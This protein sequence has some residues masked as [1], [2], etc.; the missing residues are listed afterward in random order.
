MAEH[1]NFVPAPDDWN[2]AHVSGGGGGAGGSSGW[3]TASLGTYR[4]GGASSVTVET[5]GGCFGPGQQY[6]PGNTFRFLGPEQLF[7]ALIVG[8]ILM[9]KRAD[10]R[11]IR[12]PAEQIRDTLMEQAGAGYRVCALGGGK[13]VFGLNGEHLIGLEPSETVWVEESVADQTVLVKI[14]HEHDRIYRTEQS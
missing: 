1:L 11:S 3:I 4:F 9:M 5:S 12:L 13:R 7:H 14:V 6:M 2:D 8:V 10:I